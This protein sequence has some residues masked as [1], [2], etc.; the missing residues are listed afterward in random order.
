R[1]EAKSGDV[2]VSITADVGSV[3]V[4]DDLISLPCHVSQHIALLRPRAGVSPRYLAY[5]LSASQAQAAFDAARYGGTKTQ[6]ALDDV[7][8]IPVRIPPR[9]DQDRIATQLDDL[10]T[11]TGHTVEAIKR[12]VAL[13]AEYRQALITKAVTGQ[14]DEATLKGKKPADEVVRV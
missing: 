7:L 4:I 1:T 3:A 5:A 12:Q 6:L 13:L 9:A 14:L 11:K 8:D 10:S 2:V